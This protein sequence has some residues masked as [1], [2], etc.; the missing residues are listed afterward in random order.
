MLNAYVP[1]SAGLES[2]PEGLDL[3]D[4]LWVDAVLPTLDEAE[5]LRRCGVDVPSLAEMEEIEVSNRLYHEGNAEYMTATLPGQN[6]AGRRVAMPVTFILTPRQLITVRHHAPRAFSSFPTRVAQSSAG[7]NSAER[8]F[9]GL[10]AENVAR[11]ADIL[12][13]SGRALDAVNNTVFLDDTISSPQNLKEIVRNLGCE[14][15]TH[16]WVRLSLLTL[17]RVLAYFDASA[18][19]RQQTDRL[20]PLVRELTHDI[21]ALEV[22][23]EFLHTRLGL[24]VESTLGLINLQQN[25]TMRVLSVI[26]ALFL[27]PTLIAS[28]YG[29]NFANMPELHWRYGYLM[30]LGV[31][32]G[33]AVLTYLVLKWKKWL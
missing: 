28:M 30:A 3:C 19:R 31:M 1:K 7:N 21:Q 6:E 33:S 9:L 18:E 8:V 26:S 29:M 11:L 25:T 24:A 13:A 5:L 4:A 14:S 20:K 2:Q 22:H 15:E 16:S 10:I 17:E 32:L 12:E 27:P 23:S